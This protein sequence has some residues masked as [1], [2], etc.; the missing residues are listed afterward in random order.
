MGRSIRR[1][2]TPGFFIPRPTCGTTNIDSE[3]MSAEQSAS[4]VL[5]AIRVR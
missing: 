2:L 4:G 1:L 5:D 3:R